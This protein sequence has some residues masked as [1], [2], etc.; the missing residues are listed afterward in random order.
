M[1]VSGFRGENTDNY[2]KNP[3]SESIVCFRDIWKKPRILTFSPVF[4]KM[5]PELRVG[6][7][8]CW[9]QDLEG[10]ILIIM[11][12]KS[13]LRINCL[14]PRYLEKTENLDIFTSIFL[15]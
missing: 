9:Y 4:F 15:R 11:K 12:K 14:F 13:D 5:T 6:P 8:K 3:I 7:R 2:G 10:E 1:L